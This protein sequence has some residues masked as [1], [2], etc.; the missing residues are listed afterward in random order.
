MDLKKP[1]CTIEECPL[2]TIKCNFSFLRSVTLKITLLTVNLVTM[3]KLIFLAV[4]FI[5]VTGARAQ[6]PG[7]TCIPFDSTFHF[8]KPRNINLWIQGGLLLAGQSGNLNL[9][10][11]IAV[12]LHYVPVRYLQTGI[13]MSKRFPSEEGISFWRSYELSLFAR[14]SF[15]RLDCPQVGVYAH[16]GYTNV[17]Q[18]QKNNVGRANEWLPYGGIGVYK[19]LGRSF[20]LQVENELYF[21]RR[22]D[23]V[24]LNLV[25]KLANCKY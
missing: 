25:W 8:L 16:A 2:F 20:S 12:N 17:V 5:S 4:C 21:N 19:D 14:Y 22:P 9:Y 3:R 24:S 15:I 18:V 10:Q 7:K 1:G 6:S 13:N 11:S 23:Q